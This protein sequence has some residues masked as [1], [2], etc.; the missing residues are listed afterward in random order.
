M[1]PDEEEDHQHETAVTSHSKKAHQPVLPRATCISISNPDRANAAP[2]AIPKQSVAMPIR[3]TL[4]GA[5]ADGSRKWNQALDKPYSASQ[6]I[7]YWP[8]TPLCIL[9]EIK[10]AHGYTLRGHDLP[11]E[12]VIL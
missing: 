11:L 3:A 7:M 12:Q 2:W 8:L 4:L 9:Y 1:V 5:D 10:H 6:I